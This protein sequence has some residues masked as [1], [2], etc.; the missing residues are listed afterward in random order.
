FRLCSLSNHPTIADHS[1]S[2]H[3]RERDRAG[4]Y[5]ESSLVNR[6]MIRWRGEPV[7]GQDRRE[8]AGASAEGRQLIVGQLEAVGGVGLLCC[9]DVDAPSVRGE[10]VGGGV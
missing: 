2:R 1:R 3:W 10:V 4:P 5:P 8:I 7:L 6:A 9:P